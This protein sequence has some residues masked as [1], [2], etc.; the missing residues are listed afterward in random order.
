MRP[1]SNKNDRRIFLYVNT[2][3]LLQ[4]H[5]ENVEKCYH[6]GWENIAYYLPYAVGG[7]EKIVYRMEAR[8]EAEYTDSSRKHEKAM[9]E[10]IRYSEAAQ[11]TAKNVNC[12]GRQS[13]NQQKREILRAVF[14]KTA[15][16][17]ECGKSDGNGNSGFGH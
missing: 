2:I 1:R 5:A 9:V 17:F 7:D 8:A 12:T 6:N 11:N 16:V 10:D 14:S 4:S 3:Q 13:S 15:Y